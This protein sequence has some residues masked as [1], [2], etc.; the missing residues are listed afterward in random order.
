VERVA[1]QP[2]LR[3]AERLHQQRLRAEHGRDGGHILRSAREGEIQDSSQNDT[4]S[5]VLGFDRGR[6]EARG[7]APHL[8]RLLE[9][10]LQHL[11]PAERRLS[12]GLLKREHRRAKLVAEP[13]KEVI[14]LLVRKALPELSGL[15]RD[16]QAASF[17]PADK[18]AVEH[19]RLPRPARRRVLDVCRTVPLVVRNRFQPSADT[20]PHWRNDGAH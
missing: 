9:K 12:R 20:N 18:A 4:P 11:G 5:A 10:A 19:Q 7:P 6:F 17:R 3:P 14:A 13:S 8:L 15:P 16:P 1:E 2:V